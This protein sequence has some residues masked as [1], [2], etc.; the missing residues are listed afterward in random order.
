M[1]P[2]PPF[3]FPVN[4]PPSPTVHAIG[5]R[6]PDYITL[7]VTRP[8]T[9]FTTLILLGDSFPSP[10]TDPPSDPEPTS[11]SS[12]GPVTPGI[13]TGTIVGIVIGS[14]L[15]FGLVVLIYYVSLKRAR[16]ARKRRKRRRRK[17][18]GGELCSTMKCYY[19]Y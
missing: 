5:E 12:P 1:S 11:T 2:A 7:S 15:G 6:Q 19:T 10:T 14:L 16:A 8:Y 3:R 13:S 9:T 4:E 17:G 18:K